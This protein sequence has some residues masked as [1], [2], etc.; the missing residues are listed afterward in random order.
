MAQQQNVPMQPIPYQQTQHHNKPS[1]YHKSSN[2]GPNRSY[3]H[4]QQQQ[5]RQQAFRNE[6]Q[7][8]VPPAQ[9]KN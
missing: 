7:M 1:N 5:N 8:Y 9:R 3:H 6:R 2:I 4:Q